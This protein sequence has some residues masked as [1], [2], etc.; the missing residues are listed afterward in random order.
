MVNHLLL[1]GCPLS[2]NWQTA[3]YVIGYCRLTDCLQLV[4]LVI[5][6][7]WQPVC[8]AG[9]QGVT[10]IV[11]VSPASFHWEGHERKLWQIEKTAEK[12]HMRYLWLLHV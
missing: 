2:G 7:L 3:L 9:Q 4:E 6:L 8:M 5:L 10:H 11:R 12:S 1:R